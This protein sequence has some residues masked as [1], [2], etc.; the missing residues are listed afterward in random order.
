MD[1]PELQPP[2]QAAIGGDDGTLWLRRE[3]LGSEYYRWLLISPD[4]T[5]RGHLEVPRGWRVPWI[6]SDEALAIEYDE[7]DIPWVLRLQID[8]GNPGFG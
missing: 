7:F 2:I 8:P 3:D 1:F 4:G 5:P 6:S